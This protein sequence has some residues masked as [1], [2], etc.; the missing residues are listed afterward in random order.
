MTWV[1]LSSKLLNVLLI[2]PLV[3]K[4]FNENDT[5]VYFLLI[6]ITATIAIADFGFKNT[7]VRIISYAR[8]GV[9]AENFLNNKINNELEENIN[10]NFFSQ[11]ELVMKKVYLFISIIL[12]VILVVYSYESRDDSVVF[13]SVDSNYIL[14]WSIFIFSSAVNLYGRQYTCVLEGMNEI[15]LLKRVEAIYSYIATLTKLIVII[16]YPSIVL[17]IIVEK[18]WLIINAIR[19]YNYSKK[20]TKKNYIS[21]ANNKYQN[22]LLLRVVSLAWRSGISNFISMGILNFTGIFYSNIGN[23]KSVNS[24][25]FALR[26]INLIRDFSKVPFYCKLPLFNSLRATGKILDLAMIAKTR[27][28]FSSFLF[29]TICLM[30][31]IFADSIL[32]IIGSNV[33]FVD[34]ELWL[35]LVIATMLQ[36][37]SAM[38]MQIYLT[39][40]HVINHIL[41]SIGG[42][43]FVI[44]CSLVFENCNLYAFPIS[45]IISQLLCHIWI[46]PLLSI[47]S[48]KIKFFDFDKYNIIMMLI[49]LIIFQFIVL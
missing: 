3:L 24:Y 40:N 49:M 35:F 5:A 27:M 42:I 14:L 4:N 39:T 45:I 22:N 48:L 18:V 29:M 23:L 21:K 1:A 34:I 2:L 10:W 37:Y 41:D 7:F 11:I 25:L 33:F 46:C 20:I 43:I 9:T 44:V 30:T 15:A 13:K 38:H 17:L 47:K 26:I 12:S 28:F 36:R 16:L 6:T 31:G 19:N 32:K 8:A